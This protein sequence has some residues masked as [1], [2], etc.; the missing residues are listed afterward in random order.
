MDTLLLILGGFG[1]FAILVSAYVFTVAARNYV[2]E[3]EAISHP[4][5]PHRDRR[6]GERRSNEP[7]DFPL[8]VD[9]VEL[10]TDR[11]RQPDRRGSL[12]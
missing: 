1:L 2:S 12:F 11:R 6:R 3:E 5:S 4:E 10:N 8:S 7:V 9:G